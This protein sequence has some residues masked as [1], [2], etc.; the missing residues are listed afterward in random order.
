[1]TLL[2]TTAFAQ[3]TFPATGNAGI[4][5]ITPSTN[6]DILSGGNT[7]VKIGTSINTGYSN[8]FFKGS[9]PDMWKIV[10]SP[11]GTGFPTSNLEIIFNNGVTSGDRSVMKFFDNS[12]SSSVTVG[13][14]A[15]LYGGVIFGVNGSVG[16]RSLVLSSNTA[17]TN[18][19]PSSSNTYVLVAD[20]KIG[21]REVVVSAASPFPDY[22]FTPSYNLLS[23]RE[24][25]DYIKANSHLPNM[26]SAADV[27]KDG[28]ALGKISAIL[29]EKIEEL[30]LHLIELD[31]KVQSLT[32]ENDA[33]KNK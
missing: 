13:S 2:T 7:T 11:S 9:Q 21:A 19:F 32:A 15:N 27:E 31:K 25:E 18:L 22:V 3:N 4:G 23:L 17:A 30:T 20:G 24:I 1:M 33:L 14:T 10:K 12:S 8:L 16:A 26:P 5:T 28:L 29:V 6:L